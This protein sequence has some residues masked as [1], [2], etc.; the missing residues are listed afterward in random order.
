MQMHSFAHTLKH[1][2]KSITRL[3]PWS[4][5]GHTRVYPDVYVTVCGGGGLQGMTLDQVKDLCLGPEGSK[6][7]VTIRRTGQP[8][9]AVGMVCLHC[10]VPPAGRLRVYE[11]ITYFWV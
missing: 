3:L 2:F 10:R 6:A 4:C 11:L 1:A 7:T 5:C 9:A 8:D